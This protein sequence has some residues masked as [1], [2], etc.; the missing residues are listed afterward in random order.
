MTRTWRWSE[1]TWGERVPDRGG[2][3]GLKRAEKGNVSEKK[4][5]KNKN[6]SGADLNSEKGH[7][8]DWEQSEKNVGKHQCD[9]TG[10]NGT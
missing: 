9:G 4:K 8:R 7:K 6:Q 3:R 2:K 10:G 5:K 1:R